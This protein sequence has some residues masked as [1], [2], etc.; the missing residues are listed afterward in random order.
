LTSL[1]HTFPANTSFNQSF[2]YSWNPAGQIVSRTGSNDTYA[3][4]FSN[5]NVT[6]T[7]N[8]LNEIAASGA[9]SFT[10]DARGNLTSDGTTTWT[11]DSENRLVSSSASGGT[12]LSYD[13]L[14]RLIQIQVIPTGGN[15]RWLRDARGEVI[16]DYQPATANYNRHW[17]HGTGPDEPLVQYQ[18]S[19][20]LEGR[21]FIFEDERG[22]GIVHQLSWA[23]TSMRVNRYDEYGIPGHNDVNDLFYGYTGQQYPTQVQLSY[24]DARFYNPRAGRFMQTDP[25]GYGS[26]M[27]IYGYADG[28][29]INRIDPTGEV[30]EIRRN[31]NNVN[32]RFRIA[33][34]GPGAS[35]S[36]AYWDRFIATIWSGRF[37]RYAVSAR[38]TSTTLWRYPNQATFDRNPGWNFV[39]VP[40]GGSRASVTASRFGRWPSRTSGSDA[41]HEAGHFMNLP[42]RY[43]RSTGRSNPG[44]E[45]DIMGVAGGEV[46]ERTIAEL[47]AAKRVV[48]GNMPSQGN[49]PST[50]LDYI[51]DTRRDRFGPLNTIGLVAYLTKC[52]VG[53][54]DV[55]AGTEGLEI[56][57]GDPLEVA[58]Q[59]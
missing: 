54:V 39:F 2:T 37:G 8:G 45:R 46:T 34:Y 57:P 55:C 21:R 20:G 11:Y 32:L 17:V 24:Y 33:Y 9:A 26:G 48:S 56:F 59:E 16:A 3:F 18:A 13:P 58:D 52:V 23:P 38:V 31:G 6:D 53:D 4:S 43:N 44:Y 30:V 12:T 1:A 15:R 49:R 29:P 27:N 14:G 42:D 40:I 10:H 41:A 25:V 36:R 7:H 19:M 35:S 22:S 5:A 50:Y 51:L 28:D 47:L